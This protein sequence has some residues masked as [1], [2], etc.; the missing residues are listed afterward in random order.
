MWAA[1]KME[2][3]WFLAVRIA[4][5]VGAMVKGRDV[6][7][8]EVDREEEIGEVRRGLVVKEKVRQRVRESGR[9]RQ[10]T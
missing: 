2:I 8:G 5:R 9:K 3:R 10:Q 4:R 7:E 6:L 1:E